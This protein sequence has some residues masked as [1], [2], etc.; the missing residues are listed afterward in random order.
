MTKED[1]EDKERSFVRI[2]LE[3][4]VVRMDESTRMAWFELRPDPRRYEEGQLGGERV[5]IDKYTGDAFTEEV[6]RRT[7]PKLEGL[8]LSYL[9]RHIDDAAAYA[10]S[11]QEALR[12]EVETGQHVPPA[13]A[14]P[15]HAPLAATPD[16]RQMTFLSV[17]ICGS[18]VMRAKDADSFGRCFEILFRELAIVVAQFSGKV[19]KATGDGLIAYLDAPSINTQCDA[20]VDMGLTFLRVL[21]EAVNPALLQAKLPSIAIRVGAE[22][23]KATVNVLAVPS[24]GYSTADISSDALNRAVKVEGTCAANTFRIGEALY[25]RVHVQWLERAHQCADDISANVGLTDYKIY[26]VV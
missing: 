12:I 18:T 9:P 4:R 21:N 13:E 24:I 17:D 8:P 23:G 26:E 7:A 11:R 22:H 25:R 10:A 1:N 14:L 20:A 6:W 15:P 3:T 19:F 2:D 16:T 5:W